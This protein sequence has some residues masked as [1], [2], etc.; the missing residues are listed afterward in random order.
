MVLIAMKRLTDGNWLRERT[1]VCPWRNP[2]SLVLDHLCVALILA[3][4]IGFDFWRRD[5]GLAWGWSSLVWL[6][7]AALI[8]ILQHRIGLMGHEASHHLLHPNRL[9]NDLLADWLC[10]YPVFG[11]LANYRAKHLDH[12][13]HP[14][15]P[16]KDPNLEGGKFR[17]FYAHFPMAKDRFLRRYCLGFFWPPFVLAN[18]ADLVRVVTLGGGAAARRRTATPEPGKNLPPGPS[19][20]ARLGVAYILV[21]A[22][23]LRL[24]NVRDFSVEATLAAVYL[25]GM[26]V[27]A[28]LPSRAFAS[29]GRTPVTPKWTAFF[30]LTYYS[31]FFGTTALILRH[32]G[33]QCAPAFF[34]LWVFP[35][36]YIFPYLMLVR[37]VFQHA[38]AGTGELDNSRIM[39]VGP[40]MRWALLGYG[41]DYHLV[42]HLYPNIPCYRLREV[43]RHLAAAAPEYREQV[44]ETKGFI[45]AGRSEAQTLLDSLAER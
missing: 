40:L 1:R 23:L 3:V 15:D 6:P 5:E 16:E 37:E 8:G 17:R 41:N 44:A 10:F 36:V 35:L 26:V 21:L 7:A 14:N 4:A 29:A 28:L 24:A 43:H 2:G 30:R 34:A 13:L 9:W 12:H 45:H 22:L 20:S 42:H 11:T 38:N 39:K 18:L 27:W 31:V 32:T 19:L 25:T 33:Y